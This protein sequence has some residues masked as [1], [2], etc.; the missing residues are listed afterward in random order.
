MSKGAKLIPGSCGLTQIHKTEYSP[1]KPQFHRP[2][3]VG[4]SEAMGPG[5]AG[6]KG[7]QFGNKSTWGPELL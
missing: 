6:I 7:K 4:V 1:E 5:R 2:Q 3:N